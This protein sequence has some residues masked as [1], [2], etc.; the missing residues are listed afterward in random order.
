M[1]DQSDFNK[2][3]RAVTTELSH[4]EFYGGVNENDGP[5]PERES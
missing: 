4:T 5:K 1:T 3:K 2:F